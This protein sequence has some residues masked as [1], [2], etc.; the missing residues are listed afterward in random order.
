MH[1][2]SYAQ[3][4]LQGSQAGGKSCADGLGPLH[5]STN[6]EGTGRG[7]R[8]S[9]SY[10][11][12][13]GGALSLILAFCFGYKEP[14]RFVVSGVDELYVHRPALNTDSQMLSNGDRPPSAPLVHAHGRA[15]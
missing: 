12:R 2:M 15:Y 9:R 7:G 8:R 4:H 6:S 1:L 14:P 3:E 13:S 10:T 5:F 11:Q